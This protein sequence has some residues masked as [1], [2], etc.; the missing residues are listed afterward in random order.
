[1]V[2]IKTR[3]E[4]FK[5]LIDVCAQQPT[6]DALETLW[7]L[8]ALRPDHTGNDELC[9]YWYDTITN[10]PAHKK[11][12]KEGYYELGTVCSAT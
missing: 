10:H 3:M 1:M 2:T 6:V 9:K 7:D 4:N 8:I 5:E 11:M 12:G